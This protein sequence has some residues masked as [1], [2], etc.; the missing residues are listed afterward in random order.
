MKFNNKNV[1]I[2]S[3]AVL[4]ENVQIGDNT[5]IYSNVI[6]GDNSIIADNCVIGE[7]NNNY[8][9]NQETYMNPKTIIGSD[10]L[11]RSFSIIYS[12]SIF[13]NFLNTG[14]HVTIRENSNV[15]SNCSIGTYADIQGDCKIGDYCRFQSNVTIG[16][17]SEIGSFV[18]IYPNVVLTNDPTPPSNLIKGVFIDD[19]SQI[20][21]GTI[22]MPG[23]KVGKNCLISAQSTVRGRFD[24][25]S[26]ISGSPAK[27]IGLLS[28]MPFFNSTKKR[29]Y[30]WMFFFNRGMPWEGVGFE[31]WNKSK[32]ND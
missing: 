2:D 29:H 31:T 7:P 24:D 19:Y 4:G 1:F 28:K 10:S 16:Q 15:G 14:H 5:T 21:S 26:F 12:G 3:S 17:K 22:M 27:N 9:T 30:P 11:I 32:K 6:I 20:T 25:D 13:G 18:F 23:A 8:Y